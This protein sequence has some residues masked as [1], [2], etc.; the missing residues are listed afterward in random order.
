MEKKV[1]PEGA[2][3][4]FALSLCVVFPTSSKQ[5]DC[6]QRLLHSFHLL[7]RAP[8]KNVQISLEP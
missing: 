8:V 4:H 7:F 3:V 6:K 1:S 2:G 5:T